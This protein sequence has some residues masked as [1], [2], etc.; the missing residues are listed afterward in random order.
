MKD[1][2]Y[3]WLGMFFI[4]ITL[5][6]IY[7][8]FKYKNYNGKIHVGDKVIIN[9]DTLIAVKVASYNEIYLHNGAVI[10]ADYC[11]ELMNKK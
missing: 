1:F 2:V 7:A 3:T 4:L 9:G 5:A 11:I 10:D 8:M 6:G